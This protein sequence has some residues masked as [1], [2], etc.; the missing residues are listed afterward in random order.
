MTR[1]FQT[2]LPVLLLAS[3]TLSCTDHRLGGSLSP[4]RSRLKSIEDVTLQ[5][6]TTYTYDSRNRPVSFSVSD[7]STG[8]YSYDDG[9]GRFAELIFVNVTRQE[10]T[11]TRFPYQ[12]GTGSFSSNTYG[13]PEQRPLFETQYTLDRNNQLTGASTA[14]DGSFINGVYVAQG[15]NIVSSSVNQMRFRN[16]ATYTYDT[17]IN[18]FYGLTGPILDE[19]DPSI[20]LIGMNEV[21]RFS[22]NN[23]VRKTDVDSGQVTNYTYTYNSEGLPTT[24]KITGNA[25]KEYKFAYEQY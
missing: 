15:N 2:W 19:F 6:L 7:G 18:P 4:T 5:R 8:S 21:L 16:R 14:R 20:L 23:P 25:S 10:T 11:L 17:Q 1:F 13:F 24:L 3:I 22:R 12:F 9:L